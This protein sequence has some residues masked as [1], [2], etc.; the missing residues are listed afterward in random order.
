MNKKLLSLFAGM[1]LLVGLMVFVIAEDPT[2]WG[3][4]T[5]NILQTADNYYTCP[6][7][8][9]TQWKLYNPASR[10]WDFTPSQDD[11]MK[12]DPLEV[13]SLTFCCDN[14]EATCEEVSGNNWECVGAPLPIDRCEGYNDLDNAE[15]LCNGDPGGQ[16]GTGEKSVEAFVDDEHFCY[17][18]KQITGTVLSAILEELFPGASDDSLE[19]VNC[20][21][22][23]DSCECV[24][25]D[26]VGVCEQS[27]STSI[28]HCDSPLGPGTSGNI[29]VCT[30]SSRVI[31]GDCEI[32]D[33][34]TY[35]VTTKWKEEVEGVD[36]TCSTGED[37][38]GN[39]KC[40]ESDGTEVSGINVDEIELMGCLPK[41][42]EV[43]CISTTKIS[44]FT[45]ISVVIVIVLIILVYYFLI[46]KKSKLAKKK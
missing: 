25:N 35:N 34:I 26:I 36:V 1:I 9:G 3:A 11:C 30:I 40:Y 20:V 17:E 14:G 12:D 16:G 7:P 43:P 33:T 4:E 6:T 10:V 24:W 45:G 39:I 32:T 46:K 21:Y 27:F 15:D 5:R 13:E 2:E 44:F 18:S 31:S 29:G 8:P 37:N 41:V 28:A 22:D 19:D 38:D 23:I 42:V